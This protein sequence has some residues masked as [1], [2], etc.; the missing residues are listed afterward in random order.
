M[1]LATTADALQIFAFPPFAEGT[2]SPADDVLDLVVAAILVRLL[3]A[4]EF[5]ASIRC[6]ARAGSRKWNR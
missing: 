5:F 4:L 1:I 3:G 6:L 2:L